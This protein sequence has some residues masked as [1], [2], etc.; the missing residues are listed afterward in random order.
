MVKY[1]VLTETMATFSALIED[2]YEF[3]VLPTAPA[4]A[5]AWGFWYLTTRMDEP[6]E[7]RWYLLLN[8]YLDAYDMIREELGFTYE[9][10]Q[11]QGTIWD[12]CR[13]VDMICRRFDV[14]VAQGEL[15][16]LFENTLDN[17]SSESFFKA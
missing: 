5:R 11:E 12:P 9:W 15:V 2:T 16:E 4:V 3:N 7:G 17:N 14:A 10:G 1:P 8:I 6:D 13:M